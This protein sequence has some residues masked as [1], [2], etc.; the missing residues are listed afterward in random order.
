MQ[1]LDCYNDWSAAQNAGNSVDVIYLDI[2]KVFDSVVHSKLLLKLAAYGISGNLLAWIK[3]FLTDRSHFVC[4]NNASSV[5]QSVLSSVPQ[6]TVAGPILFIIYVNDMP[7]IVANGIVLYLFADDSKMY[8]ATKSVKNCLML[9][10][11]LVRLVMWAWLW[12]LKLNVEK[13]L[14]LHV[15]KANPQYVYCIDGSPLEVPEHVIDFGI[16]MSK[17]LTFHEHIKR[18]MAKCYRKLFILKKCFYVT[19]L[20]ILKLRYVLYIQPTLEYG[21][22][23]WAPH[24]HAEIN[25]LENFQTKILSLHEYNINME[26]LD[27]RRTYNDLCWYNSILHNYIRLDAIKYFELNR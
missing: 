19:N 1:R 22:V 5:S 12:Q 4:M 10:K 16:T 2:I 25:L 15:R 18:M 20:K 6:G 14:V 24:S 8:N 7:D 11:A 13:C 9:Q 17:S 23:I 27:E 3:C 21:S 26:S